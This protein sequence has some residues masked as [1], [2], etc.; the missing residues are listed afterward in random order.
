MGV[1]VFFKVAQEIARALP[2]YEVRIRE[3]HHAHKQDKPS[4]TALQVGRLIEDVTRRKVFYD[5]S[6]REGEIVGDHRV[7]F[8]SQE[9]AL[10]LFHHAETR[11]IFALGALQAAKWVVGKKPGLYSMQDVLGLK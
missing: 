10:E 4:G 1:N 8:S 9:D 11:D 2:N 6:K 5:E 7:I 3:A